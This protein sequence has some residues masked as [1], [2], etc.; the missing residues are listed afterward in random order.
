MFAYIPKAAFAATTALSA[1]ALAAPA[2]A[3]TV[4]TGT[5]GGV[6]GQDV[7]ASTCGSGSTDATSVQVSGC[8]DAEALNGGTASTRTQ[9]TA[10][11]R[12]AMQKST[13]VARD[14]D[15]RARSMTRTRVRQGE[16]VSSRTMSKYK[17]RGERPVIERQT[18]TATPSGTTT[19]TTPPK[20]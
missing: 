8:A 5:S 7:S 14:E 1:L 13:A 10:N 17:Q 6:T 18:S 20:K 12:R 2:A 15:E 11:D 4:S 9:G 3:Q 16:V 19:K